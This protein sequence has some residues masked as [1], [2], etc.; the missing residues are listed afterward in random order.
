MTGIGSERGE[1]LVGITDYIQPPP[2]IEKEAFPEA[3]LQFLPDWHAGP[4]AA[5]HWRR[6]GALLVW[7]WPVDQQTVQLLDSCRMVVRYGVGFDTI[8]RE[9]LAARDIPLCNTPDYGTEEVADT[10]CALILG[11]QRKVAAYDRAAR[12]FVD[13]WQDNLLTPLARTSERTLGVI[14]VGRIGTAVINR[15]RPFGYRILGYDPYKPAGHEKAVG[16]ERVAELE[17]LLGACDIVTIHCPLT[18]ETRGMVDA[19]FLDQMREGASLVNTARGAVLADLDCLEG[20]LRSGHLASVGLDVL[21]SEPPGD[22]AL[23]EAWRQD[24]AW[25]RGRLII[26]PHTAWYSARAWYEMRY[27]AAETARMFLVQGR[28]RSHVPPESAGGLE[29]LWRRG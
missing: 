1:Y 8:D 27:K 16:Y 25:L 3:E 15:I 21:P 18:A 23:I 13:S 9:A 4:E 7:H 24:A 29:S 5:D 10:T 2:H 22:H 11:L 26:T 20:A 19:E 6:V 12:G 17:K 14:G 28:L